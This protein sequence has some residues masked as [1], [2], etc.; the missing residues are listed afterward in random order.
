MLKRGG[1]PPEGKDEIEGIYTS[2][3]FTSRRGY[4]ML[5]AIKQGITRKGRDE[6]MFCCFYTFLKS[7][8]QN[9]QLCGPDYA[10][11][12]NLSRPYK[13]KSTR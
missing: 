3:F 13:A 2:G 10:A 11:H 12:G 5:R 4:G 9:D 7:K 6:K 8:S 1:L